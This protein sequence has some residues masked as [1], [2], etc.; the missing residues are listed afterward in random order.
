MVENI[1]G[2]NLLGKYNDNSENTGENLK[3]CL[4]HWSPST[5]FMNLINFLVSKYIRILMWWWPNL[6]RD[7]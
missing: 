2:T 5:E 6:L 3:Y 1:V 4:L 7:P